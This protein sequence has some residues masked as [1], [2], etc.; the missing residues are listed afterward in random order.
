MNECLD[1]LKYLFVILWEYME[2]FAINLFAM[3][4]QAFRAK[5]NYFLPNVQGK[6]HLFEHVS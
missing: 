4:F 1:Y 5:Q 2:Y 6:V 3:N